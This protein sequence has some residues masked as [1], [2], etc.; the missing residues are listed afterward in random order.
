[1]PDQFKYWCGRHQRGF[2]ILQ[3]K[4]TILKFIFLLVEFLL[5][6]KMSNCGI[7]T[8]STQISTVDMTDLDLDR[9]C[10]HDRS[11]SQGSKHAET[12]GAHV[13]ALRTRSVCILLHRDRRDALCDFVGM[14]CSSLL[15][16]ADRKLSSDPKRRGKW[17]DHAEIALNTDP[18]NALSVHLA[19]WAYPVVLTMQSRN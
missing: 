17:I 6:R 11:R 14:K 16:G 1:M 18:G 5:H 8:L 9:H 13:K 3:K 19:R 12:R 7:G 2:H 4:S 15:R 10:W